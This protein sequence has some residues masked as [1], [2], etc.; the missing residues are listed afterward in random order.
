M[1]QEAAAH[2]YPRHLPH[3]RRG[4]HDKSPQPAAKAGKLAT[5]GVGHRALNG[6]SKTSASPVSPG[7]FETGSRRTKPG[8]RDG[9][10]R[11]M[12]DGK[13]ASEEKTVVNGF[14][15]VEEE[16]YEIEMEVRDERRR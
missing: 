6:A 13:R 16:E 9:T 5:N 4:S 14:L 10:V 11:F 2:A 15:K 7:D 3:G 8:L 12:L 1:N